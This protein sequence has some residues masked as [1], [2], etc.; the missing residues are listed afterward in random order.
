[1]MTGSNHF[2]FDTAFEQEQLPAAFLPSPQPPAR[3]SRHRPALA[4]AVSV[5][6]LI[7][8]ALVA[9]ASLSPSR[10]SAPQIPAADAPAGAATPSAPGS[11]TSASTTSAEA[12]PTPVSDR[13]TTPTLQ[14][15]PAAVN[16]PGDSAAAALESLP[17]KGKAPMSGYSREMFGQAWA[18]TDRN[19]CDT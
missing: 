18:D 11:P 3:R 13:S 12:T 5:A 7:V 17:V 10:G 19:G 1:M 4:L 2:D 6:V 8:L 15:S 16:P 9:W 14:P